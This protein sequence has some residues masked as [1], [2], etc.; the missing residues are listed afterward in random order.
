[1]ETIVKAFRRPLRVAVYG[2]KI[3]ARSVYKNDAGERTV[4]LCDQH[5][6]G[7]TV[8]TMTIPAGVDFQIEAERI[9]KPG[10]I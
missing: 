3:N 1:M 10:F 9:R 5:D 2:S 4:E 6:I 7:R 8:G